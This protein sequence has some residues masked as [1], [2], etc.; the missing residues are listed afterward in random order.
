MA[1]PTFI[2]FSHELMGLERNRCKSLNEDMLRAPSNIT[3]APSKQWMSEI[4]LLRSLLLEESSFENFFERCISGK[5]PEE[6]SF[7][8]P[9]SSS[10]RTFFRKC[11]CKLFF[12]KWN[13]FLIN[14][15]RYNINNIIIHKLLVNIIMTNICNSFFTCM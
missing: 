7:G 4:T 8:S 14:K 15:L 9:P 12:F 6:G 3:G 1:S 2:K 11:F 13:I 5:L 10:G